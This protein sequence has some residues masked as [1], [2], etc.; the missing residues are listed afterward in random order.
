MKT[1]LLDRVVLQTLYGDSR[2]SMIEIFSE[3]LTS[4]SATKNALFSAF[5][6]GNLTSLKRVLHYHGPSFMYLGLPEVA[7]QFKSLELKC[8]QA[9]NHYSLSKDFAELMQTVEISW[10]QAKNEMDYIKNAV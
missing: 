4:Y 5:E 6:S 10:H 7:T 1:I 3:F 8:S 2:E 9:E